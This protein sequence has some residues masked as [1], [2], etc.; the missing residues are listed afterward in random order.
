M[1]HG[2]R[3]TEK[4][5][6]EGEQHGRKPNFDWIRVWT[7]SND[8]YISIFSLIHSKQLQNLYRHKISTMLKL[9]IIQVIHSRVS[10]LVSFMR[11]PIPAMK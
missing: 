9:R 7:N 8:F 4:R 2:L 10:L 11:L 3:Q 5:T 1:M 6:A